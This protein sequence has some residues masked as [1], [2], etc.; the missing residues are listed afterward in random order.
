LTNSF[1]KNGVSCTRSAVNNWEN[2][3][4]NRNK[5]NLSSINWTNYYSK[6]LT[7]SRINWNRLLVRSFKWID[8]YNVSS[9][10]INSM[11]RNS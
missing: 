6:L 3:I 8:T 1:K 5:I 2:Q 9:K 10:L 4:T 7:N 11:S